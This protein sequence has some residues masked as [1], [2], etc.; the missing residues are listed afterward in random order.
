MASPDLKLYQRNIY[1]FLDFVGDVGGLL[2]GL[3]FIGA[4]LVSL[5]YGTSFKEFLM[6]NLFFFNSDSSSE[7][8]MKI[9]PA[10]E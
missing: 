1:T 10:Q 9:V 2:D 5:I 8:K 3:K 6:N 7:T 4:A